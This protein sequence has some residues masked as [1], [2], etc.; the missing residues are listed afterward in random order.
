MTTPGASLTTAQAQTILAS[1]NDLPPQAIPAPVEQM[2][3][4]QA[5]LHLAHVTDNQILGI[6]AASWEVA[7]ATLHAYTHALGYPVPADPNPCD[8]SVYLKFNPRTGLCYVSPYPE[9][10]RG[11]LIAFQS[12]L[13]DGINEMYGHLPL[14]LFQ[15]E[16]PLVQD[17]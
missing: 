11:V 8:G 16:S 2:V 14:D 10:Y 13:E 4:Q 1:F 17:I 15:I 12:D 5:V 3:V 9:Q 6:L 7:M